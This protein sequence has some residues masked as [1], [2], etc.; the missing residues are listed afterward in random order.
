M[1]GLKIIVDPT[2]DHYNK[3]PFLQSNT[4]KKFPTISNGCSWIITAK[5]AL[6]VHFG[7]VDSLMCTNNKLVYTK[8]P[9]LCIVHIEH[10]GPIA[11]MMVSR[12]VDIVTINTIK[13]PHIISY[14]CLKRDVRSV[15]EELKYYTRE[16]LDV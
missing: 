12:V 11:A 1:R 13:Y 15:I 7:G 8:T 4:K 5:K 6:S 16:W 3:M 10:C 2:V 9:H 14:V